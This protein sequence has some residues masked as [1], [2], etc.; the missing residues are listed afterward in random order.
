MNLKDWFNEI[1][2]DRIFTEKD[3][4]FLQENHLLFLDLLTPF[5]SKYCQD[6][7]RTLPEE[8]IRDF[9]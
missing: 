7:L 6:Y 9:L 5:F 2:N 3:K 1:L 4:K 8:N